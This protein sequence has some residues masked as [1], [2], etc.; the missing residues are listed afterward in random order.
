MIRRWLRR[1]LGVEEIDQSV[2]DLI[3]VT[4]ALDARTRPPAPAEPAEPAPEPA[5][6]MAWAGQDGV[7]RKREVLA[8]VLTPKPP[9][10]TPT[11]AATVYGWPK[12][13]ERHVDLR[14]WGGGPYL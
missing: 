3:V 8:E 2:T 1:W 13:Y 4:D 12:D 10:A 5:S 11:P 6:D 14:R 7:A 9:I